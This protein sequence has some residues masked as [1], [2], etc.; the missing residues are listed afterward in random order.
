MD[1]VIHLLTTGAINLF[2]SFFR[3]FLLHCWGWEITTHVIRGELVEEIR[4]DEICEIMQF[5]YNS[6]AHALPH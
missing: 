5:N 1:S 2:C 3:C 6:I 4:D